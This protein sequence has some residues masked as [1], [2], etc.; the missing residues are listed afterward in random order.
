[1]QLASSIE[2][3]FPKQF[4]A[5]EIQESE[6]LGTFDIALDGDLIYSKKE[7]G[8]LPRPGEVENLLARRIY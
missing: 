5:V 2:T 3:Q 1:M 8:R 6:V 7:T 4:S